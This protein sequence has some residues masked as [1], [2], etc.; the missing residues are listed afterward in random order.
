MWGRASLGN[1]LHPIVNIQLFEDV[2]Q[3]IF[4]RINADGQNGCDLGIR[5]TR[6]Y[7]IQYFDFTRA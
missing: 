2:P 3:M 5:F 6:P 4:N 1:G 7:P